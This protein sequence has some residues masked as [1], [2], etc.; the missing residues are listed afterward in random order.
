VVSVDLVGGA[1]GVDGESR[2][3]GDRETVGEAF[4]DRGGGARGERAVGDG[5]PGFDGVDNGVGEAGAKNR[6]RCPE[7]SG[8]WVCACPT[9]RRRGTLSPGVV[10]LGVAWGEETSGREAQG[11]C[12]ISDPDNGLVLGGGG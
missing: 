3:L 7:G 9:H 12:V 1:E 2:N 8:K 5:F 10:S 4:E 6:S 11:S